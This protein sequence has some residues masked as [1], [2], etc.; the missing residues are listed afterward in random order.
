MSDYLKTCS[1]SFPR[2]Q[3]ASLLVSTLSSTQG[4]AAGWQLQWLMFYSMERLMASAKLQFTPNE[5]LRVFFIIVIILLSL[6]KKQNST[7]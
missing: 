2:A 4:G 6:L 5:L 1:P 7:E 3:S